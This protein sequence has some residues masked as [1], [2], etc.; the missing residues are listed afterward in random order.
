MAENI[1]IGENRI[2]EI[3]LLDSDGN[4]VTLA[5]ITAYSVQI[6]QYGRVIETIPTGPKL[7]AGSTATK[8]KIEISPATSLLFR[9]GEVKARLVNSTNDGLY[10]VGG[11][12]ISLPDYHILTAYFEDAPEA[13]SSVTTVIEHYRGLYDASGNV[14][15]STGGAG[16]GGAILGGDNW[17]ISVAGVIFGIPV[18]VNDTI[19]ANINNP[20]QTSGNWSISGSMN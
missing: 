4:S 7:T 16:T 19:T 3:E 5:S 11:A 10:T 6:R 2:V 9:E 8:L 15:P 20:G 17:R 14:A 1:T 12:R 18:N 13:D